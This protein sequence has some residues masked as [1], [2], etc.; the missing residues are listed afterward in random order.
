MTITSY[1]GNM[2]HREG[3]H[4]LLSGMR[5][6]KYTHGMSSREM[7]AL[8]SLCEVYFPSLPAENAKTNVS[9][10]DKEA[11]RCFYECS[12]SQYPVPDEVRLYQSHDKFHLKDF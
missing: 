1:T 10:T 11:V 8:G 12:G 3:C 6:S 7:E 5:E 9:H 4:P 2:D